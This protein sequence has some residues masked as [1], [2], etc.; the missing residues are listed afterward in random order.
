M[1][2]SF[3]Q[4]IKDIYKYRKQIEKVKYYKN[5]EG[6]NPGKMELDSLVLYKNGTFYRKN[7]YTH[8]G[9][10]WLEQKGNW[11][12]ENGI[13]FLIINGIK[14]EPTQRKW[15]LTKSEYEYSMKR[16]KL[17]P[18]SGFEFKSDQKLKRN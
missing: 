11:T 18:N 16:K 1:N 4:E 13:L 12:V 9:I 3:S 8:R 17:I 14:T 6:I 15:T 10:K 2:F 7:F 5:K